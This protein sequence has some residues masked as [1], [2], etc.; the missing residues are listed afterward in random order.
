MVKGGKEMSTN[1]TLLLTQSEVKDLISVHEINQLI[2]QTYQG[3][4]EGTVKNPAK[5]TLDLGETGNWPHYE[6]FMNAMPAYVGFQDIAGQKW[7]GGFLGERKEAGLPYI[8]ALNL[9]IDPHLGNFLS[10]MDGS[11]ISN[12]RTGAQAAVSIDYLKQKDSI[13][14]GLYGA[15]KQ[16]R[17]AVIAIAEK[18]SIDELIVWNHHKET[19]LTFK[20]DMKDIVQGQIIVC[21]EDE[22]EKPTKADFIITLTPSQ[23][24][25]I[26]TEWIQPG[27]VVLPMGSFQEIEDDLILKADKIIVDH[28][29]QTLHRGVLKSLHEEGKINEEDIYATIGEIANH[30]KTLK[31]IKNEITICI[32]L[33]TGALDVAIAAEVYK[34]AK[35]QNIGTPFNFLA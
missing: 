33:G 15:G 21:E 6:G 12:M 8:T 16:A 4:G 25:L 26:Q 9:L 30:K 34:K 27:T 19:A 10:V 7:V 1:E 28:V 3:F 18:L 17:T 23:T 11:F 14:L 29:V 2:D 31:N 20:E 22:P 35:A 5:V 32:P 24:P 13:T